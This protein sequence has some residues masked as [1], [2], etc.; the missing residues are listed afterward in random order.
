MA[1][2]STIMLAATPNTSLSTGSEDSSRTAS[3]PGGS[4]SLAGRLTRS[5]ISTLLFQRPLRTSAVAEL[6]SNVTMVAH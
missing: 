2:N 1:T 6:L 5:V 4:P 3:S